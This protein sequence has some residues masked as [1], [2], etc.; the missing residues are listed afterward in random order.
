MPDDGRLTHPGHPVQPP[1]TPAGPARNAAHAKV[2]RSQHLP[3]K[4]ENAAIRAFT[5]RGFADS[6][7]TGRHTGHLA[8]RTPRK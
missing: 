8:P 3:D 7:S 5:S 4:G 1:A 2:R 6:S